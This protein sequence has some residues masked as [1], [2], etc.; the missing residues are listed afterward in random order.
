MSSFSRTR[1]RRGA[2]LG[3]CCA[4]AVWL[5]GLTGPLAAVEIWAQDLCFRLRGG[6]PTGAKVLLVALDGP[7]LDALGKPAAYLSP[8]LAEVVSH[9][10]AQGAAAI[11]IDL[12][13]VHTD[14][15]DPEVEKAGGRGDARAMGRAVLDAGNVVL[16]QWKEGPGW[17]RPLPQWR[18]KALLDPGPTDLAF[19]NLTPDADQ[20]VRRQALLVRDGGEAVPQLALAVHCRARGAA[21]RAGSRAG[22]PDPAG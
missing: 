20:V 2:G 15:P 7:S 17:K 5:L 11:G 10:K 18:L 3:L 16:A 13:V 21:P 9:L 19:V 8:E 22:W 1:L 4:A 6:R 14:R 12:L